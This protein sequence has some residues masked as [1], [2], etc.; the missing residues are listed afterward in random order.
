MGE[1]DLIGLRQAMGT[2]AHDS[3]DIADFNVH[4]VGVAVDVPI[5]ETDSS[6]AVDDS[7]EIRVKLAGVDPAMR[8]VAEAAETTALVNS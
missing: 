1:E 8:R 2:I 5:Y 4:H 6:M 7:Q 3:R